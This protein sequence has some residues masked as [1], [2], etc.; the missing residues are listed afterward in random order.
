MSRPRELF[1][2]ITEMLMNAKLTTLL[3]TFTIAAMLPLAIAADVIIV[4]PRAEVIHVEFSAGYSGN[5]GVS[6][7]SSLMHGRAANK[8]RCV[9]GQWALGSLHQGTR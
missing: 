6:T 8:F 1:T 5:V 3:G 2:R 9:G 4:L 7:S